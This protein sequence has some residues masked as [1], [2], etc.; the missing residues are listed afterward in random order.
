MLLVE[1][2]VCSAEDVDA[3]VMNGFALRLAQ[4]GPLRSVDYAGLETALHAS[5]YVY[6]KTGDTAFKPPR[7]LEEKV[8]KGELGLKSGKGF[9]VYSPEEATKFSA[10]ANEVV[11]RA[12]KRS[13]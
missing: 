7:I 3:V 10:L 1:R 2:G 11:M 6:E 12:I 8:T 13:I 9:Y 4:L 5:Q